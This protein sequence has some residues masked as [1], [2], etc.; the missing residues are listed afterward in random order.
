ME[1]LEPLC[2]AVGNVKCYSC[3]GTLWFLKKLT[4]VLP[5]YPAALLLGEL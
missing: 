4:K 3:F 2:V 5:Y 1:K